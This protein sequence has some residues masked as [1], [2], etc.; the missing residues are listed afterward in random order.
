MIN[1]IHIPR[2]K[3]C[4]DKRIINFRICFSEKQKDEVKAVA[5]TSQSNHERLIYDPHPLWK[6]N[7]RFRIRAEH[8]VLDAGAAGVFR[9]HIAR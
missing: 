3:V 4:F 7:G 9:D 1:F 5:R 6:G 2:L 8:G